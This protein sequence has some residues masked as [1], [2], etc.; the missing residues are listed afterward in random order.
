M[1]YSPNVYNT[2]IPAGITG[3]GIY[4]LAPI[5][6]GL[7]TSPSSLSNSYNVNSSPTTSGSSIT[8]TITNPSINGNYI[9]I[10]TFTGLAYNQVVP[11]IEVSGTTSTTITFT[12]YKLRDSNNNQIID[13]SIGTW[14]FYFVVFG[15]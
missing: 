8:I 12:S 9:P 5:A 2:T 15:N 3:T 11:I 1:S 7:I 6:Y 13:D 10:V 14:S 4:N